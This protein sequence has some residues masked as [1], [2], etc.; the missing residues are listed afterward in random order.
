M[1]HKSKTFNL[2]LHFFNQMNRQFNK[3]ISPLNSRS[4]DIFLPTLQT[5]RSDN[6]SEFLSNQIQKLFHD[7]GIT[8]QHSF[9]ATPQKNCCVES[10]HRHVLD[11][12]RSL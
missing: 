5:I 11:V 1:K 4:G 6:G 3:H 2:L 10:K 9:V 7:N 8:H 12:A